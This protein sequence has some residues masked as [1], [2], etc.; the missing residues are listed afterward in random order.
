MLIKLF[1]ES[2]SK[3]NLHIHINKVQ[4]FW[5]R[6]S[7]S[8]YISPQHDTQVCEV[9]ILGSHCNTNRCSPY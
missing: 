7:I 4:K 2:D 8:Q 5:T 6:T 3:Y 1:K 9:D